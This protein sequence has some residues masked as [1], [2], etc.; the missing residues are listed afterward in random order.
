[1]LYCLGL[2]FE[3]RLGLGNLDL[4]ALDLDLHV[5]MSVLG[6]GQ[7]IAPPDPPELLH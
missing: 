4:P 5:I 1:M 3:L 7:N 2:A 6:L